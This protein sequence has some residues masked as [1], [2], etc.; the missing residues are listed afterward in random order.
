[1]TYYDWLGVLS[2]VMLVMF[3]GIFWWAYNPKN[4]ER[5]EDAAN[6]VLNEDTGSPPNG[7]KH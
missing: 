1:M 3:L 7:E 6:S 5:F 2:V 4:K